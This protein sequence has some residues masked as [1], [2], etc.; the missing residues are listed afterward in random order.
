MNLISC[1]DW[2]LKVHSKYFQAQNIILLE[3]GGMNIE[4]EWVKLIQTVWGNPTSYI[5]LDVISNNEHVD[6]PIPIILV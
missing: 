2:C 1:F 5:P 3:S 6:I 4:C